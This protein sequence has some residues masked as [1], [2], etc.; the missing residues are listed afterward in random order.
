MRPKVLIATPTTRRSVHSDYAQSLVALS[1]SMMKA[2]IHTM[3]AMQDGAPVTFQRDILA[4]RFLEESD[5]T[6]ML[7]VD[8]DMSFPA[9]ICEKL[10]SFQKDFIGALYPHRE[11]S[12]R[13][14]KQALERGQSFDDAKAAGYSVYGPVGAAEKVS[15]LYLIGAVGTGLALIHRRCFERIIQHSPP[16]RYTN[17]YY[18]SKTLYRFFGEFTSPE[19]ELQTEDV[20]FCRRYTNAGGQIWAY[21]SAV[22]GHVGAFTYQMSFDR[23][24]EA[25]GGASQ[26]ASD[27]E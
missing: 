5:A 3:V 24:A 25:T 1:V 9:D 16:E 12:F 17:T 26:P 14:M 4:Y 22:I 2:G 10:L 8:S 27:A 19:G 20:S 23:W 11:F 7:F 18:K 6:H 13:R 15:G 21:P